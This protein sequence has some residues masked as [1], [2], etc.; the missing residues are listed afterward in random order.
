MIYLLY[1]ED[2]FSLR[3]TLT[4]IKQSVEPPE[5][6]DVNTNVV[7]AAE[8]NYDELAAA[9]SK[10]DDRLQQFVDAVRKA[11]PTGNPLGQKK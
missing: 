5:L 3:E 8:V 10:A 4:S 11:E 2:E 1:G 6:R 9:C 7:K